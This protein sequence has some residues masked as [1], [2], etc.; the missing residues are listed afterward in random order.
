MF[1]LDCIR[2]HVIHCVNAA[3]VYLTLIKKIGVFRNANSPKWT[4]ATLVWSG[5][6]VNSLMIE[7][8]KFTITCQLLPPGSSLSR[9]DPDLSSRNAKSTT[10]LAAHKTLYSRAYGENLLLS[11]YTSPVEF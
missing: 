1:V 5:A 6:M 4:T 2:L 10:Q 9:I 11:R 8:T 7:L 3:L